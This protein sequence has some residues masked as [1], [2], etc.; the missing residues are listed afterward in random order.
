DSSLAYHPH[1]R[2]RMHGHYITELYGGRWSKGRPPCPACAQS[3]FWLPRLPNEPILV[4]W[5]NS[6]PLC[7]IRARRKKA[8]N[9]WPP[10]AR[11]EIYLLGPIDARG[12]DSL[13]EDET[14]Y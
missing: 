12:E 4:I 11:A 3:G 14:G 7:A 10:T 9:N 1:G 13:K 6:T 2:K 5:V 8:K